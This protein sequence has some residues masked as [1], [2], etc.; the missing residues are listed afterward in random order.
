M[1][2]C[3]LARVPWSKALCCCV[4][5]QMLCVC[6][7]RGPP[8]DEPTGASLNA[9]NQ[10]TKL[11]SSQPNTRERADFGPNGSCLMWPSTPAFT[12]PRET[13]TSRPIPSFQIHHTL[14]TT[15]FRFKSIFLCD[16]IWLYSVN[17]GGFGSHGAG[18]FDDG[19]LRR[20]Q[21]RNRTTFTLQ[22]VG[23]TCASEAGKQ[24]FWW[25]ETFETFCKTSLLHSTTWQTNN[26]II[27]LR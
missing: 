11:C 4:R 8:R 21:R 23:T 24:H 25:G 20:K 27:T 13:W 1:C 12:G 3:V 16:L 6:L 22:Q 15:K 14:R 19:F 9:L 26:T 5:G 17:S 18:D 7:S 2:V 10:N